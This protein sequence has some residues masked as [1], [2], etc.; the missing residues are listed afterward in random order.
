MQVMPQVALLVQS[1]ERMLLQEYV[2]Q[3]SVTR[4]ND[5]YTTLRLHDGV[6]V[7]VHE[8]NKRF[9]LLIRTHEG[10]VIRTK[11]NG[12]HLTLPAPVARTLIS[13]PGLPDL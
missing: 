7:R 4:L 11:P 13:C 6:E 12:S 1:D 8:L 9:K 10:F 2:L 3:I 5:S